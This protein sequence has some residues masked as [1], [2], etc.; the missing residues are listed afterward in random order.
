MTSKERVKLAFSHEQPDR[1]PID[2]SANPGIDGK[3]KAHFA[4]ASDDREGLLRAL[5][6]DFRNVSPRYVGPELH[7]PEPDRVIS[8]WGAHM[9]KIEHETGSYW[10]YCDW[11]LADATLEEVERFPLPDPDDFDYDE[12]VERA[13]AYGEYFVSVGGSGTGDIINSTGMVRTMEQVLVDMMTDAPESAAF[14]RRKCS[15][16]L[17]I[18]ER[19]LERAKGHVD[20]LWI[21]EDLGTQIGPLISLD[22]YRAVMKPLHRRFVEL[23]RSY[24][25]EVMIHCCG[26]S[27]WAF[28]D[29]IEMGITVVDTL[30]PEAADMEPSILKERYG[31]GLSFHGMI[32]TAGPLANGT[33]GD[34]RRSVVEILETMKPGGG[35]AC[36]PTHQIQD[37]SPLENVLAF[38]ETAA[39]AG[40]YSQ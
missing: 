36:A 15:I 17:E 32:S 40:R 12:A 20:M 27:S 19:T 26:S 5:G 39:S 24:G 25:L 6:V 9:R 10:D 21:G 18:M 22:L 30:Q 29:F 13:K 8:I 3:L 1:V 28:A 7:P 34:V 4:L 23:G 11:P 37:N 14:F 2:Y 35:Y 33:P 31:G 38:Y 16:Q